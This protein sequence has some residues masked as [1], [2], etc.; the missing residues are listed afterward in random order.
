M[1][2]GARLDSLENVGKRQHEVSIMNPEINQDTVVKEVR[3]DTADGV[4]DSSI[5]DVHAAESVAPT[6]FSSTKIENSVEDFADD[7][8]ADY[9]AT[10]V[11]PS[12]IN[13]S[14]VQDIQNR[15]SAI[16]S[17]L[18]DYASNFFRTYKQPII[19]VGLVI[20]S[21]L[22][23]RVLFA[24]L[25]AIFDSIDDVPLLTSLLELT[26]LGFWVWFTYRYLLQASNRQE[27]VD[28]F[29]STKER[30]LGRT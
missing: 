16:L 14:Q 19:T 12:P 13:E 4:V 8:N 10:V 30:I 5:S 17:N 22:V 24:T 26:G 29:N 6:S 15:V 2:L 9:S 25:D 7:L 11:E 28:A 1:K 18:P 23:L 21:I 20:G 27:L 3:V